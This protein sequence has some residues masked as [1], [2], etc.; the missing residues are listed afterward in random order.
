MFIFKK[1]EVAIEPT[2]F[3]EGILIKKPASECKL[4][5]GYPV[6]T[7][8]GDAGR[9]VNFYSNMWRP[10][11]NRWLDVKLDNSSYKHVR[12]DNV[13]LI[14]IQLKAVKKTFPLSH[15][16]YKYLKVDDI[17][18]KFQ[19]RIT[20]RGY[21]IFHDNIKDDRDYVAKLRRSRYGAAFVNMLE[22]SNFKIIK[23]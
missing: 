1:K 18:K 16:C 14:F 11:E 23:K 20:N 8:E 12:E 3:Y 19:V 6:V 4:K 22:Q 17:H 10:N 13:F 5:D 7:L 2:K 15:S 9:I 21:A